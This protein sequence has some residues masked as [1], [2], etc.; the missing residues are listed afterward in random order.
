MHYRD[1]AADLLALAHEFGHAVQIVASW[2]AGTGQM[3]PVARECCAFLA[4]QALL[5]H[6]AACFPVLTYAHHADDMIYFGANRDA[7]EDAMTNWQTGYR[8]EWNYPLARHVAARLF[9][10]GPSNELCALYRA[11]PDGGA[12]VRRQLDRLN[13]E[14]VAA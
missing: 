7:L 1:S 5:R 14:E 13:A 12:W 9:E 2:S 3:P 6:C 4:E 11:G 10:S 8:Y